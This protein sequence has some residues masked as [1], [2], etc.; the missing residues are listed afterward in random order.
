M[1]H[2][3]GEDEDEGGRQRQQ[4]EKREGRCT[5]VK[6]KQAR[7]VRRRFGVEGLG[8]SERR[9]CRGSRA[10]QQGSQQS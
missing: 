9:I 8:E 7:V 1:D 3:E 2:S 4:E 6:E 10:G 5:R